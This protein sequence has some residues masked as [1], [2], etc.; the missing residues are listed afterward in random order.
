MV[1]A[2]AHL[3]HLKDQFQI[4]VQAPGK[5]R[6]EVVLVCQLFESVIQDTATRLFI[7]FASVANIHNRIT[8]ALRREHTCKTGVSG[9]DFGTNLQLK[10]PSSTITYN[11]SRLTYGTT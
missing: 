10:E 8:C 6:R 4:A 9:C 11:C 1:E 2:G 5:V 7:S 3:R